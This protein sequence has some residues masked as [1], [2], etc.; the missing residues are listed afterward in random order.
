MI[1]MTRREVVQ[2]ARRGRREGGIAARPGA[3]H[4]VPAECWYQHLHG[5]GARASH[6]AHPMAIHKRAGRI[7]ATACRTA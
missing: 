2:R 4:H 5:S 6:A 7:D 3:L 1:M